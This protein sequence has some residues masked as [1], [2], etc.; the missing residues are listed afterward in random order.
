MTQGYHFV[1][2]YKIWKIKTCNP[3]GNFNR[4]IEAPLKVIPEALQF[5]PSRRPIETAYRHVDRMY[6]PT[7]GDLQQ[8]IADFLESQSAVNLVRIAF[9]QLDAA[10]ASK[11]IRDM[12]Q[13]HVDAVAFDPFA[14]V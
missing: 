10:R 11:E 2:T 12:Q 14:T 13:V 3:L 8:S 5:T 1:V 6:R 4:R 9:G 7:A